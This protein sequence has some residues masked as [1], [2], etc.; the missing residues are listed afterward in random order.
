MFK[1]CRD[2]ENLQPEVKHMRLEI[3][4]K[5]TNGKLL[6]GVLYQSIRIINSNDWI[7]RFED[8]LSNIVPTWEG[9]F[10]MTGD[11]NINM[12]NVSYPL[13]LQYTGILQSFN[14]TQ[15]VSKPTRVTSTSG[16]LVDH[17]ISNDPQKITHT[18]VLPCSSISD[19]DAVYAT[20][21]VRVKKYLPPYKFI[22]N[23]KNFDKNAYQKDFSTLPLSV[24]YGLESLDDKVSVL[25]SLITECI[26]RHVALR[27]VKVTRPPAHWMHSEEIEFYKLK[28]TNFKPKLVMTTHKNLG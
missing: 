9:I 14:L 5:N 18:D 3:P 4:S 19:H 1:R 27:R 20:V 13:V 17:L 24:V 28:E 23:M 16:T 11:I 26:D 22:C 7:E 25:N 15:H 6:L 21:N 12:F 10:V 2:I 8:L